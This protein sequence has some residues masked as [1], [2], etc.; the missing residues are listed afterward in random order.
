MCVL[1]HNYH[2]GKEGVQQDRAKALE[3]YARA[4]EF[5]SSQAHFFMGN[6]YHGGGDSKKAKFHYEAA[7]MAG[8]EVARC[9][10][11]TIKG[12]SG[13]MW[14]KLLSIGQLLHQL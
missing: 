6:M 1:A 12:A 3:L 14:N 10:L 8:H 9:N 4:S 7:A 5:G 13:H 2:Y 11:G